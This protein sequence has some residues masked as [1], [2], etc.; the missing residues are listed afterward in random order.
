MKKTTKLFLFIIILLFI[1]P[2]VK[3][4]NIILYNGLDID[5]YITQ[6]MQRWQLPGMSVAIIRNGE[7]IFLKGYGVRELGKDDKVDENTIF[8]IAS[9]TKAFTGTAIAMLESEGKLSLDDKITK[10]FPDFRLYD[11]LA[12]KMVTV[13]D[14]LTHRIGLGTFHGDFI[15]WGTNFSRSDLIYKLRYVQP[16]YDF[17]NGYGYC[18]SG[19]LTAGEIIPIITGISWDDYINQKFFIPLEMTRTTTSTAGVTKFDNIAT[20]HTYDE[21]YN[22][23]PVP[24]RD[25][26]NIAPA[27]SICSSAKDMANWILMQTKAGV[28]KGNTIVDKKVLLRT[29]TPFNALSIPSY[30]TGNLTK[31]HFITYGLGWFLQDYKGRLVVTHTGGYDGMLSRTAFMP[32][33]NL[34]VV[35]LTN[36]DQNN[37][38]TSLLYQI[39]DYY[40]YPNNTVNWDSVIFTNTKA[41]A[42]KDKKEWEEIEKSKMPELSSTFDFAGL[43]GTYSNIQAGDAEIKESNG[44]WKV[45]I[46]C[47]PGLEGNLDLWHTDTLLCKYNDF[48][49]GKCLF[50]L[51]I[52]NGKVTGFKIRV[53]DFVD[54][55]Y[56]EFKRK[57]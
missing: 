37:V 22:I 3:P 7:I 30:G 33:D 35:I 36:N 40:F 27:G 1:A 26:D 9:N 12:S 14:L 24:W 20:P 13:K 16:V 4:Q 46:T 42:E 38:Y 8:A 51:T 31:R 55:L 19:F 5:T 52:E 21:N 29:Q 32:E 39:F 48:V 47:R 43:K 34:G 50:P 25:V 15:T 28:F 2:A 45:T 53:Y 54:P 44:Q 57:N 56:Y 23:V 11:S 17:R 10:Y 6:A 41:G 18:N 49:L